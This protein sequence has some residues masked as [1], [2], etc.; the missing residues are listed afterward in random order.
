MPLSVTSSSCAYTSST[1]MLHLSPCFFLYLGVS[2]AISVGALILYLQHF[3]CAHFLFLCAHFLSCVHTSFPVCILPFIVC[4]LPVTSSSYLSTVAL[5]DPTTTEPFYK[6]IW[7]IAVVAVVGLILIVCA[8]IA[9]I[10]VCSR[11]CLR[12]R[13]GTYTSK[14]CIAAIGLFTSRHWLPQ[15]RLHELV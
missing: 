8:L 4:I 12:F 3:L 5:P 7:F 9:T 15:A 11:C 1:Y 13:K 14:Q 2:S 6:T 10:A